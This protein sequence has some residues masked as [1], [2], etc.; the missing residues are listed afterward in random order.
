MMEKNSIEESRDDQHHQE[1]D[2]NMIK[3][4]KDCFTKD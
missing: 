3:K 2:H 4:L 1:I